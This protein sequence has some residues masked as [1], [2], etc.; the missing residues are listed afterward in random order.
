MHYKCVT[1]LHEHYTYTGFQD[2]QTAGEICNSTAAAEKLGAR[3]GV[4]NSPNMLI[5]FK[6]CE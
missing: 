4:V 3:N 2:H 6:N 5:T 1:S